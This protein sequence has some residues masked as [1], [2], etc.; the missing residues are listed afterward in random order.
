MNRHRTA[1]FGILSCLMALG[2]SDTAVAQNITAS[3]MTLTF[4]SV[5]TGTLSAAQTVQVTTTN[6]TTVIVSVNQPWLVVSG[7]QRSFNTSGGTPTNVPVQVDARGL[8]PSQTPY[9]GTITF[10]ISGASVTAAVNVSATVTSNSALSAS[11][12]SLMFTATQGANVGNPQS[13]T[14]TISSSAGTLNYT[15][16]VQTQSGSG[17]WLLL[18]NPSGTTGSGT[19]ITVSVN[20]AGLTPATYT[21]TITVQSATTAD[22]VQIPVT[23]TVTANA[24]LSVSPTTFQPFLYQ[25]NQAVPPAQQ[26]TLTASSGS[27]TYSI[28]TSSSATWLIVNPPSGTANPTSTVTL[29]VNPSGLNPGVYSTSLI[30]TPSG[31]SSLAGIPVQLVV[32]NNPLLKLSTNV[33]SFSASFAGQNP[34]DQQVQVTTTGGAGSVGFTFSSDSSWLTAT[35]SG[36]TTPAT[37]TIHANSQGLQ[38]GTYTG[39]ITVRP[40]NGDQY[41]ESIVVTLTV[42]NVSTLVAG[43]P[44]LMFSY[45]TSQTPPPAQ[46]V[47]LTS[48]GQPASFTV[49][50]ST[51]GTCG[52]N[53]LQETPTS[54]TTPATITVSVITTG[55]QPGLCSGT[56]TVSY[57]SGSGNTSLSIPVTLQIASTPLLNIGF[58]STPNGFG[59]EVVQQNSGSITRTLSLT[60]TDPNSPV[61]FNVSAASASNWLFV[62]PSGNATTPQNVSV[63]ITPSG[64]SPGTYTGTITIGSGASSPPSLLANV[65]IPITLVVNPNVTVAV[66]P[67][68]PL[69]FTMAQNGPVPAAQTLTLTSSG[70]SGA[71]F[72]ATVQQVTGGTWV[73]VSPTSGSANGQISVSLI[74]QAVAALSQ[75]TYTNQITLAFQ[76]AATSPITITVNLTVGPPQTVMVS[77]SSLSFSYQ[78]GSGQLPA[79]QTLQVTSTGGPV[80]VS[81]GTTSTGGWLAASPSSGNTPLPVSVQVNPQGLAAGTFNGTVSISAAGVL[82]NPINVTVTLTVS[83]QPLPMPASVTSSASNVAEN[84][85]APGELITIKG[86]QLGPSTAV[87]FKV[88]AQGSVDSTLGGVQ[89]LFDNNPGTPIYVSATQINVIVPYEI[90]GRAFTNIVVVYQTQRSSPIQQVVANVAPGIFTL[91]QTGQGQGAVVNQNG[92]I[93]GPPGGVATPG[94]VVP[95]TPASAGTVIAVY[96]TGGGQTD[97]ASATG[98]VAPT[99][100]LRPL[101]VPVSVTIGGQPAIVTF[102]G[103][104]PGLVSGVLQVNCQVPPNIT[105][106]NLPLVLTINGA[107]TTMG[108][109]V[110]VQ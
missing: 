49:A 51:G 13:Q 10:T 6:S 81:V 56:I 15:S 85:I 90:A 77:T 104:A 96:A 35:S 40:T 1:V 72:S 14:V 83:A 101:P 24:T 23:L 47:Q 69:S 37:L 25:I 26:L 99:T 78:M 42:G 53:W 60:S 57:N 29:S 98:S 73:Q 50:T 12:S 74:P 22:S 94:G 54:G 97:P 100:S 58:P 68:G 33:L 36:S 16:T 45:E 82:A 28:S 44:A 21:G 19:G 110:A 87:S 65:S 107:P 92:T 52:A 84:A 39:T 66:S 5:P 103:S 105:G 2:F 59:L 76:N 63:L 106:N 17:N 27:V 18:T 30:I 43:P 32:S 62:T 46:V 108:V 70:G 89:V 8:A 88:N 41:S 102:A 55:L 31:G 4:M 71:T 79:S 75:G 109:T 11:P 9:G 48:L 61:S 7:G 95:T 93:N 34:A 64:L 91:N 67:T 3:P 20:P 86:T 38:V 80:Q